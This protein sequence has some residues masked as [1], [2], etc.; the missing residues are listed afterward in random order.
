MEYIHKSGSYCTSHGPVAWMEQ[1]ALQGTCGAIP[2]GWNGAVWER[3]G[4]FLTK[5]D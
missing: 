5:D 2:G 1:S 4:P 3:R